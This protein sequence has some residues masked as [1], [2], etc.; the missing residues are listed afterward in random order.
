MAAE[1][2]DA[3]LVLGGIIPEADRAGLLAA[4]VAAV[5][6]PKDFQLS[7]IMRDIA[8]LAVAHRAAG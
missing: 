3:P 2:V 7:K 4:G 1:G 5:Y 6:T 8:D